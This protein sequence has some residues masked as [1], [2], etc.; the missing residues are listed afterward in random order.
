MKTKEILREIDYPPHLIKH[1]TPY[2]DDVTYVINNKE[3][4]IKLYM[5]CYAWYYVHNGGNKTDAYRRANFSIYNNGKRKLIP[6]QNIST[7]TV[8]TGGNRMYGYRYIQECIALIREEITS[9]IKADMPT[10]LLEQLRIQATYDP[11]MF[12]NPDGSPAFSTWNEIPEEYRCCI[13]GISTSRYGK[14]YDIEKTVIKLVDRSQAR[15]KL[16]KLAPGLLEPDIVHIKHTT[17]DEDG[18]EVG[19]NVNKL[20]DEELLRIIAQGEKEDDQ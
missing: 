20:T 6:Q 2:L 13:E 4:P 19:F 7:S 15:E 5:R 12:I 3:K 18:K 8:T 10:S 9:K 17:I 14:N 16:L 1:L 11:S